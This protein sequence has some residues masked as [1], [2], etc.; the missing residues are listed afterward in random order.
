MT[1]SNDISI[2]GAEHL[3]RDVLTNDTLPAPDL[4][5]MKDYSIEVLAEAIEDYFESAGVRNISDFAKRSD[6]S[7]T[8]IHDIL[9]RKKVK[10][11]AERVQNILHAAG[12]S[13]KITKDF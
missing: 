8:T 12:F 3:C 2:S 7:R 13:L 11:S 1:K 9:S 6:V 10:L 4:C 5:F